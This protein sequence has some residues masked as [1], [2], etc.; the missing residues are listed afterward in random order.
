M[1]HKA[2]HILNMH[3]SVK[4]ISKIVVSHMNPKLKSRT[5]FYSKIKDL[6]AIDKDNLPLEY[7]GKVPLMDLVRDWKKELMQYQELRLKHKEMKVAID[8]YPLPV[9][10]GSVKSLKIPLSCQEFDEKQTKSKKQEY[11]IQGSFRKLEF[12]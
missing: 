2:F 8:M 11:G 6:K 9:M 3:K 7:G 1:R 12:D 5:H 4:F 10:E